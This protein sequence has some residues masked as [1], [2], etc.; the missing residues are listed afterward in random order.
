MK[1]IKKLLVMLLAVV[2]VIGMLPVQAEAATVKLNKTSTTV[3]VG[4]STTLKLSGTKSG[5]K[6]TSS[7]KS[8]ATVNSKGRVTAKK[9]GTAT[10]TAKVGKKSYKCKVTVKNPYLNSTKKTLTAGKSYTLKI[11]GTTAKSWTSSK[12]S[13][14]TVNSKGKVTAKK[15][16]TATITCKG[17]NGKTYICRV[18]VK[19]KSTN[20]DKHK[21][22]YVG[23]IVN[24]PTCEEDG[25]MFYRCDCG[26][27]DSYTKLIPAKG[28]QWDQ[29]KQTIEASCIQPSEKT[30][31]CTVCGGTKKEYGERSGHKYK[32]EVYAVCTLF[33]YT[34]HTCMVC[35]YSY[36]DNEK[37]I[38][39]EYESRVTKEPACEELGITTYYCKNC[40]Y[41]YTVPIEQTGHDF[42]QTKK[43]VSCEGDGYIENVCRTCG[44]NYKDNWIDALPHELD[45]GTPKI[46]ATNASLGT[47]T[48]RCKNCDHAED[49]TYGLEQSIDL[50]NGKS[51]IVCGYWDEDAADDCF[52]LLNEYRNEKGADPLLHSDSIE[53]FA[54]VRAMECAYNYDHERPN[55]ESYMEA[56][57]IGGGVAYYTAT[58]VMAQWKLSDGHN[59]NMLNVNHKLG[60]VGCFR[61]IYYIDGKG[62]T[63]NEYTKDTPIE[64]TATFWVQNF[65]DE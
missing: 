5:I 31:T 49:H 40:S 60:A 52:T 55:G 8:V 6:W 48:Y 3:Y 30:Y 29:G 58:S 36:K 59:D 1:M 26:G 12:K 64:V 61:Q 45:E 21:H 4:S 63:T 57:N 38:N 41:M 65:A 43:E 34:K 42:I 47:K 15:S 54:K 50:G 10:I 16:G 9:S 62:N 53:A 22:K 28:H 35:N 25:I 33:G 32:T 37:Y 7:K 11:T 2:M 14:A 19:A 46:K 51:T 56:E 23:A 24:Q 17:K 44:F 13:V 20:D 27:G 39:H 18:T